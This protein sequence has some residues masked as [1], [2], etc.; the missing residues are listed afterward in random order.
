MPGLRFEFKARLH[1]WSYQTPGVVVQTARRGETEL[2]ERSGVRLSK[3]YLWQLRVS[4]A[5]GSLDGCR[6]SISSAAAR[7]RDRCA[8]IAVR[9]Y[10]AQ[11]PK[12]KHSA[13]PRWPGDL[14]LHL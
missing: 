7:S 4:A 8:T 9:A 5:S 2:L 14:R 11:G 13:A 6:D 12:S 3:R 10:P 1:R